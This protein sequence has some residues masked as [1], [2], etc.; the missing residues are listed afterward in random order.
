MFSDDDRKFMEE[1]FDAATDEQKYKFAAITGN[2]ASWHSPSRVNDEQ[3]AS[4]PDG[5][6][7]NRGQDYGE[8]ASISQ[9]QKDC[10]KI[11]SVNP[12]INSHIRDMMGRLTGAE[13]EVS[14]E[15][16]EIQD[17]ID[18]IT[19]DVRN[20]LMKFYP[21]WI[22]RA[23]VEGELFLALTLHK[24]GFIE[25]DFMSPQS[26]TGDGDDGSGITFHPQK[27]TIPV[28][29]HFQIKDD[30]LGTKKI[31]VPSIYCAYYPE[32]INLV[33]KKVDNPI[34]VEIFGKSSERTYKEIGGYKTFIVSWDR[35]YLKKRNISHIRTVLEWVNYYSQLKKWE[36]D[37]KKSSGA[38]L[39]HVYFEDWKA[40]NTWL[41]MT[42]AQKKDTGL[43][44]KKVPGGTLITGP[45]MKLDCKNPNLTSINEQDTDILHMISSG[46]NKP[47][48][49]LTGK[50]TGDT[51]SG[52][53]VSRG[54]Q[55]D[56]IKDEI[57][58]WERFL[59]NDLWRSILFLHSIANPNFKLEY[60]VKLTVDFKNKK[61]KKVNK[62]ISA[63]KL[64]KFS[65]PRS[66]IIDLESKA[67]ALLGV[68]HQSVVESLGIP[69]DKVAEL[70]GFSN[71][72]KMRLRYNDEEDNFPDLPLQN[73]I[74]EAQ[75]SQ[76]ENNNIALK[77]TNST[78]KTTNDNKN[79]NSSNKK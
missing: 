36:I 68:N 11:F 67:K 41:N 51:Y 16:E 75:S 23:E 37:H 31:A 47:S 30:N 42:E 21:K 71:Y 15:I 43:T 3:I 45:G 39:W 72:N 59:R 5:F 13:F 66:E 22:A 25:I 56:R 4:D 79:S 76:K 6:Y 38:Y 78:Q 44:A 40:F 65:F 46:L 18:L 10:W 17:V 33:K 20:E 7:T 19:D 61:P 55:S 60:K 35:G 58:Y 8:P 77:K 14:A 29:Y 27:A 1:M 70:L 49:M 32:F 69:R 62:I 24:N 26:L 63:H 9:M 50:T 57:T 48:D 74:L 53:K 34:P 52:V 28:L 2:F 12:H 54:P 73:E 64:L